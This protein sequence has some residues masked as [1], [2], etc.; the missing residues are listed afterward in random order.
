[1]GIAIFSKI[2]NRKNNPKSQES[3]KEQP[4]LEASDSIK[5]FIMNW[6]KFRSVA[7]K[8]T[9]GDVWT[10]GYGSTDGVKEGDV[11]TL[12]QAEIWLNNE[13]NLITGKLAKL[14]KVPVTQNQFD[15]LVSLTYNIGI[16]AFKNSTLL[17]VLNKGEY[18]KVPNEMRRWIYQGNNMLQGLLNRR[19]AE[20]EIYNK[21]G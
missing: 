6:E 2:F 15:A 12:E 1:M 19:N 11:C 13:V 14:I 17:K 9:P 7:Y 21:K 3:P 10:I 16:S 5:L 8:P 4:K 18:D 20:I